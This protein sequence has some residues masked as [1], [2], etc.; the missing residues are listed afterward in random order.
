MNPTLD[1]S[2]H[3]GSRQVVF[4]QLAIWLMV[5]G[6]F[7]NTLLKHSI[8]EYGWI[9]LLAFWGVITFVVSQFTFGEVTQSGLRYWRPWGWQQLRW[10]EIEKFED[11]FRLNGVVAILR[12]VP[13]WRKRLEFRGNSML[14]RQK[15]IDK[16]AV[17]VDFM[18]ERCREAHR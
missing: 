5:T 6:L 16:Q 15:T 1:K 11:R 2:V 18:N 12:E 3:L 14:F 9:A 13:I 7:A 8:K 10:D 4:S 17:L